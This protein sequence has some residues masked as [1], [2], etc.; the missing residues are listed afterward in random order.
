MENGFYEFQLALAKDLPQMVDGY[1]THL[2]SVQ[3]PL[4]FLKYKNTVDRLQQLYSYWE[5]FDYDKDPQR[6][7]RI[8]RQI[9][10]L[11]VELGY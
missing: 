5:S 7:E 2:G 3:N 4:P 9:N 10:D 1:R 11:E 6:W 8:N